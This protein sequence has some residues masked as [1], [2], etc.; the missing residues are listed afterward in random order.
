[1]LAT[2]SHNYNIQTNIV[3]NE[4]VKRSPNLP[5]ASKDLTLTCSGKAF[6]NFADYEVVIV[7]D[8]FYMF[9]KIITVIV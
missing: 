7:P 4:L 5:N 8:P 6:S 3:A 2:Y 1:M 9:M